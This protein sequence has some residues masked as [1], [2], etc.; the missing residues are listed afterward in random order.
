MYT[1]QIKKLPKNTVEVIIEIP[2]SDIEKENEEALKRLQKNL[3][4]DGFRKGKVPLDVAKKHLKKEEIFQEMIQ[5]YFSKIYQ[6]I[7]KKEGLKPIINPKVDLLKAKE[8]EDWQIKIIIAEKPQVILG[9]Y[10]NKIKQLK[11]NQKKVDIWVPGKNQEKK[12]EKDDKSKLLNSILEII[13]KEAKVEISDLIIEEELN[14]RLSRLIDDIQKL[15]LTIETYAKSKNLTVE[16]LKESFKKEIEDT[17]KLEFILNEI[18]DQEKI[19]V[20]KQELE[21]LFVNIKDEKEKQQAM[22]NSYYYAIII[23]KQKTID[24]L[25]DL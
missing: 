23:R 12:E 11:A 7:V 16:E 4:V 25:L 13:L 20:E 19:T 24:Y 6:E 17:Y 21:K 18:A 2:K 3:V 10:K 5:V 9:D 14:Y 15:G 22:T 8:E 1:Y